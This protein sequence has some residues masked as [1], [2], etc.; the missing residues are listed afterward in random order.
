MIT[1]IG[2]SALYECNC[3]S[4][5]VLI[6]TQRYDTT[7]MWM[8]LPKLATSHHKTSQM[9]E[10]TVL[11]YRGYWLLYYPIFLIDTISAVSTIRNP[12]DQKLNWLYDDLGI[13]F[14]KYLAF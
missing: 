12:Q 4:A 5:I 11:Q 13:S 9:K 7:L 3:S 10:W 6:L 1:N 2:Q 14:E 8:V